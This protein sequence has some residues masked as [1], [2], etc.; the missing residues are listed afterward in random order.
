MRYIAK[1]LLTI[2]SM[3]SAF[4]LLAKDDKLAAN[5]INEIKKSADNESELNERVVVNCSAPSASGMF[6][7]TKASYDFG[8]SIGVYVFK[9]ETNQDAKLDWIALKFKN[10]DLS[11]ELITGTDFGFIIPG[12]QFFLT[13]MKNGKVTA[14]ISNNKKPGIKEVECKISSSK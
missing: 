9:G 13:I 5:F 12:G 14:G 8:K 2:I 6:W 1:I 10:D 11:S 7:I 3:S 4:P